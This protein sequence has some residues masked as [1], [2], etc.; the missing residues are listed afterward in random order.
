MRGRRMVVAQLDLTNAILI[1][2]IEQYVN[3]DYN[4]EQREKSP[5]GHDRKD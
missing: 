1:S 5:G 3:I 2:A 4:S